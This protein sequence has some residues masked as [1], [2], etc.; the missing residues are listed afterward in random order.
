MKTA[1]GSSSKFFF[2]LCCSGSGS[3]GRR[4]CTCINNYFFNDETQAHKAHDR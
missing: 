3:V 1:L 4:V 2:V